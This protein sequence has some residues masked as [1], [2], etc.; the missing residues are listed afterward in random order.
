MVVKKMGFFSWDEFYEDDIKTTA[1]IDVSTLDR[2]NK[3]RQHSPKI[4]RFHMAYKIH[5][6]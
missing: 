3:L 2:K 4:V 6:D 5:N 1:R